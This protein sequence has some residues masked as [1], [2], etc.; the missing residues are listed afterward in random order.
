MFVF[1]LEFENSA[2]NVDFLKIYLEIHMFW[3]DMRHD[4]LSENNSASGF[5]GFQQSGGKNGTK[6]CNQ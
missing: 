6:I 3:G 4:H 5:T 2:S 1:F